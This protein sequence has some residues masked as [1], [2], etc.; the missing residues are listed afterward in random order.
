MSPWLAAGLR[1]NDPDDG[2]TMTD[3]LAV[4]LRHRAPSD[5]VTCL[6]LSGDGATLATGGLFDSVYLW[7]ESREK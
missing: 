5:W 3:D 7:Q 4:F 1:R 6:A 2:R